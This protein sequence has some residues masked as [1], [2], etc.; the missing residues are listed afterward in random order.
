M[1]S[2]KIQ[3]FNV[4]S[5]STPFIKKI[6]DTPRKWLGN[7]KKSPLKAKGDVV[8]IHKKTDH[9][10]ENVEY[11]KSEENVEKSGKN[12]TV[13]D[14]AFDKNQ[15]DKL[16]IVI[17]N[18]DKILDEYGKTGD[19]SPSATST[20]IKSTLPICPK[21]EITT[22]STKIPKLVKAKTCSIIES[23]CILK[24]CNSQPLPSDTDKSSS[25]NK[26]LN[27]TKS[28]NNLDSSDRD[29]KRFDNFNRASDIKKDHIETV[30]N[31]IKHSRDLKQKPS[32]MKENK[33]ETPSNV[34]DMV[35]RL[36]SLT[37]SNEV[38]LA[39]FEETPK[40]PISK[41]KSTLDLSSNKK[42]SICSKIPVNT[43]LRKYYPSIPCDLN[44]LDSDRSSARSKKQTLNGYF[45][46][47]TQNL[48]E[49][50]TL[51]LSIAK[52]TNLLTKSTHNLA[53]SG[54]YL[55]KSVQN[56]SNVS[57]ISLR[58]RSN[59]SLNNRSPSQSLTIKSPEKSSEN[60][61]KAPLRVKS[62]KITFDGDKIKLK[63]NNTLK[64]PS[65][66][67]SKDRFVGTVSVSKSIEKL[68]SIRIS[69]E[70]V[71]PEDTF[72]VL[73]APKEKVR[74][75]IQKLEVKED[76]KSVSKTRPLQTDTFRV[77]TKNDIVKKTDSFGIQKSHVEPKFVE[78]LST[79]KTKGTF[80]KKQVEA[81]KLNL[82]RTQD[83]LE[84]LKVESNEKMDYYL[85]P[86]DFIQEGA[87]KV[88]AA[89]DSSLKK[90]LDYNS[91]NSDDSGNI[92]NEIELDCDDT[93]SSSSS[94]S[95]NTSESLTT[96]LDV[97][98][99]GED[100]GIDLTKNDSTFDKDEKIFFRNGVISQLETQRDE[101]LAGMVVHLQ[102]HCRG[103]LA[104]RRLA[105][106]KLQDMAVRCIQRNVRKFI[107]VRDWPWWRLL[108]RV[109]PLLNVHRTEEELKIKTEEL[110]AIKL[111]L[112]KL[113]NERTKL[114][115]DNDK[116][117]S[118]V[119]EFH[120][121]P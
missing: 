69:E 83:F 113:E 41:A 94:S 89:L 86:K 56:L 116:L 18:F 107:A 43:T 118:K 85:D 65:K 38:D 93:N 54:Q 14:V 112:E 102:A 8:I 37:D 28:M 10:Y 26:V 98:I 106:R 49:N 109:T 20:P 57:K 1:S 51:K 6:Y 3:K 7:E 72:I 97:S 92:S 62:E 50:T 79:V 42:L 17:K 111:K 29:E 52:S 95:I 67:V 9:T 91:D 39:E 119:S 70:T 84:K 115:H 105:Q 87:E 71:N 88:V 30:E 73:K 81:I 101:R 44:N 55:G 76:E 104:R 11:K 108:V 59:Q 36:N 47:S 25:S 99:I 120:V 16:R 2:A 96:V 110:E 13:V 40:Q 24:K 19:G 32:L 45:A 103:Y 22:P 64:N 114:K 48:S 58:T 82:Q 27:K 77:S 90:E 60:V 117:E 78:Q 80:K 63:V 33:K 100:S 66:A 5:T 75:V 31:N 46:K 121:Y 35:K 12:A 68:S 74:S 61:K 15:S 4:K 34:K 23:K 53:K 21:K